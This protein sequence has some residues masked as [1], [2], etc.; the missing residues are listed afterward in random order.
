MQRLVDGA[1]EM[2]EQNIFGRNG[3]IGFKFERPMAVGALQLKERFGTLRGQAVCSRKLA[4]R[5]ARRVG[6][7]IV[8]KFATFTKGVAFCGKMPT[9]TSFF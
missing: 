8:H 1:E 3:R 4:R 6:D 5:E 7:R 9:K 2:A